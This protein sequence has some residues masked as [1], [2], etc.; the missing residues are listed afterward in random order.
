[1]NENKKV[2][3]TIKIDPSIKEKINRYKK[4]GYKPAE[5][6]TMG[7]ILLEDSK[8]FELLLGNRKLEE[9]T[10]KQMIEFK[11]SVDQLN[12]RIDKIKYKNDYCKLQGVINQIMEEEIIPREQIIYYLHVKPEKLEKE[13]FENKSIQTGVPLDTIMN[14]LINKYTLTYLEDLNMWVGELK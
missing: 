7:L 11:K 10:T 9:E 5:I 1:M 6:I 12:Q 3:M 2:K 4:Y 13:Y 8:N 14:E